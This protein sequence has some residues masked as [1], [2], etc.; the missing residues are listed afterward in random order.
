MGDVAWLKQPAVV[1]TQVAFLEAVGDVNK[2]GQ[3]IKEAIAA[4][5]AG[6]AGKAKSAKETEVSAEA[7]LYQSLAKLQLQARAHPLNRNAS[8]AVV[9]S[10][11]RRFADGTCLCT[12]VHLCL[13]HSMSELRDIHN[14]WALILAHECY[15]KM[16]VN[17]II[18]MEFTNMLPSAKPP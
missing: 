9:L 11:P 4:Q 8:E 18:I 12:L 14:P 5:Q 16:S 13:H 17:T 2:A 15:G 10:K 3:L 7:Y 6:K 1:A